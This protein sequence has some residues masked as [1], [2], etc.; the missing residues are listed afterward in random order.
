M[1]HPDNLYEWLNVGFFIRPGRTFIQSAS[2]VWSKLTHPYQ[3]RGCRPLNFFSNPM[4]HLDGN[5]IVDGSAIVSSP[6]LCIRAKMA[7]GTYWVQLLLS[8]RAISYSSFVII[9]TDAGVH[10]SPSLCVVHTMR[11]HWARIF[12]WCHTRVQMKRVAGEGEGA[13]ETSS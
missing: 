5:G 2:S 6:S 9:I 3:T 11:R 12:A 10:Y 7:R 8:H 4:L 1:V 13:D